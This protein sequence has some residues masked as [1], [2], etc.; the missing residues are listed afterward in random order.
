MGTL[1][2]PQAWERNGTARGCQTGIGHL[3]ERR[4]PW[5]ACQRGGREG[6]R[7]EEEGDPP[8]SEPWREYILSPPD[9][10]GH[11]ASFLSFFFMAAPS[12][13]ASS[14]A[15]SRIRAATA[16]ATWDPRH[17]CDLHHSSWQCWIPNPPSEARDQTHILMDTSWVHFHGATMGT[18]HPASLKGAGFSTMLIL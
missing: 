3:G 16:T 2:K 15:R 9:T 10:Q 7:D 5:G 12:A 8:P 18:P 6:V 13:C 14:G 4:G 17:V 1:R 11:P